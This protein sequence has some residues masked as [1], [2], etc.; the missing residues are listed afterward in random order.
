MFKHVDHV[1]YVVRDCDAVVDY[2][3]KN[4]GMKPNSVEI[5]KGNNPAKEAL[6]SV[7]KTQIQITEPLKADSALAKH[8]AAHG[9]GVFHVAWAIDNILGV[10]DGLLANGNKMRGQQKNGI[11]TSPRGGRTINI[12]PSSSHGLWFQ[13]AESDGR[14]VA[15]E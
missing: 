7:G 11:S 1:H 12:D 4:F 9:P 14:E 10:A 13:L 8:L 2:I 5:N 6:Y 15:K 3:E